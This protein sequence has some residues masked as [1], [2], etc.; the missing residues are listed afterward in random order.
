[1]ESIIVASASV[2]NEIG[3][4]DLSIEHMKRWII[5][6][7][8]KSAELILFPELNVSGYIAAPIA[9]E[10]AETVPG[11]STEKI[12]K[13]AQEEDIF[14]AF[15]IIEEESGDLYC[16]HVLV[17]PDGYVG[18]QRKIHVPAQEQRAWKAGNAIEVFDI[19]RAKVGISICRDSFFGE[20]T[21]TLYFKGAEV[22]LMPFTYYNVPRSEY[23]TGT[24]HGMSIQKASW[25]NGYFAVVCNSAEG[26]D[27]NEWEP[28]GRRFP[29]WAGV[30]DPWG[31]VVT[32]VE[33]E[34]NDETLI[35]E[36]L[37]KGILVDRRSHPNFL[38]AELRTGL[39][40]F[41]AGN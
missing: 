8:E 29:G 28:K 5:K 31:S 30:I 14:I 20:Y 21:R 22:V 4:A 19:G 27:P 2:R 35:V 39:Y 3:Q 10:I 26:R 40:D 11:P 24:I 34:G 15:G 6:A 18:K 25:T 32:F 37:D 1:M 13:I 12:I 38:A 33:K 16:T 23:L 7:R 36:K 9:R 17:G 41:G